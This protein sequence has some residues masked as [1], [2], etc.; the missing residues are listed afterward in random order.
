MET[1]PNLRQTF[2]ANV[3]MVGAS[4]HRLRQIGPYG[5]MMASA[6]MVLIPQLVIYAFFQRQIIAGMTAGAVKG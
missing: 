2:P 6:T 3:S 4:D 1:P 5:G